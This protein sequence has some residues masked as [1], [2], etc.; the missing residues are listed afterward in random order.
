MCYHQI[1]FKGKQIEAEEEQS[2]G[3]RELDPKLLPSSVCFP[4]G[5]RKGNLPA[6]SP[7]FQPAQPHIPGEGSHPLRAKGHDGP[8]ALLLPE[9]LPPKQLPLCSL[10]LSQS[11][12]L[13]LQGSAP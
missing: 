10:L 6:V 11:S 1:H 2:P 8:P 5:G 4:A 9:G 7:G 3:E 13:R 12:G